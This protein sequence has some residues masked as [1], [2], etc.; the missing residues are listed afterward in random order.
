MID[1][2]QASAENPFAQRERPS[3]SWV[4]QAAT[5][6]VLVVVLIVHMVAHHFVV[7][8]GLR[9]Y[10]EVVEYLRSP[11]ILLTEHV[12]LFVVT[13]H[14]LLGVRAVLLDLGPAPDT[15]RRITSAVT[16]VGVITVVYGVWLLWTVAF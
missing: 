6:V 12:F 9:T 4:W 5:G 3:L 8:G 1:V 7:D 11:I 2:T 10:A 13:L 16:A 14:A 15:Q